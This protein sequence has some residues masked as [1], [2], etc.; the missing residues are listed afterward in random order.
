MAE[1]GAGKAKGRSRGEVFHVDHDEPSVKLRPA[2]IVHSPIRSQAFRTI[3]K[4]LKDGRRTAKAKAQRSTSDGTIARKPKLQA[5]HKQQVAV[6]LT[7]TPNRQAGQWSAHGRYLEREAASGRTGSERGFGPDSDAVEISSTLGKWQAAGDRNLFKMIISPGEGRRIDLK[8]F[9]RD[10]LTQLERSLGTKL[11]WVAV[12]HYNTDDPHVHVAIRGLTDRQQELKFP[13]EFIKGPLREIASN[14]ATEKLGYRTEKQ[15]QSSR[16]RQ[17]EQH[18]FTELD[19]MLQRRATEFNG[20]ALVDFREPIKASATEAAH[21]LRLQQLRRLAALER[22]GLAKRVGQGN[23]WILDPAMETIL[24][25]RQKLNDRLKA[26][27]E[28]RHVA[29]DPRLPLAPA[30]AGDARIVGRLLGTGFDDQRNQAYML[31]E[32]TSGSVHY[33]YQT[34]GAEQARRDGLKVGDVL[35]I[36]QRTYV[37]KAGASRTAQ[38]VTRLDTAEGM[39]ANTRLLESEVRAFVRQHGFTPESAPWGGWLGQYKSTLAATS[40]RMLK[41]GLLQDVNG[42]I[43]VTPT[44]SQQR[45]GPGAQRSPTR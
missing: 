9:T 7:Y 5:A 30:P 40:D 13:R 37:D 17:V 1:K 18:R 6:R 29:S 39:L 25:E 35:V 21:E 4:V 42:R 31:V 41:K 15:I 14:L 36:S 33:L 3:M 16:E 32:N 10:Y 8:E 23:A 28:H 11:D 44:R 45:P 24:R 26:L 27:H 22:L 34:S 2:K 43:V 19:R 38:R 20:E 12:D